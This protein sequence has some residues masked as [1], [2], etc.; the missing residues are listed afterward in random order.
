M[1]NID[2]LVSINVLHYND[3]EKTKVCVDSCLRQTDKSIRIIIIDNHSSNDSLNRLKKIY[4]SERI[5]FLC[6]YENYG[7]AKGNNIGV[8]FAIDNG[9]KYSFLLNND[10]ELVGEN[11][12]SEMVRI[13]RSNSNCAVV[14][15]QIFD[16]TKA[17]LELLRNDS[18]YLNLLRFFRILP[19]NNKIT[20]VI[21]EISEA[22][23]AALLVDN[24]KFKELSGFPEH[25]YMYGEESTFSKKVLWKGYKILWYK[26]QDSYVLHHHDKSGKVDPW[27][28]YLMGRNRGLEYYE[29]RNR[30]FLWTLAY[31][32]FYIKE[33]INYKSNKFYIEGMK[34][35]HLLRKKHA[36]NKIY[37]LDGVEARNKYRSIDI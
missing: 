31:M 28:L 23:G 14:A 33:L 34:K 26:K 17:G 9:I 11:L 22:Q 32:M 37:Y 24:Q 30:N 8:N 2:N 27:R 35:S 5:V 15:P 12:V 21:E 29:N 4:T 20:K 36:N 10:T 19:H 7:F 1:G 16:V 25:Y 3:Y 18:T 13:I 6:N